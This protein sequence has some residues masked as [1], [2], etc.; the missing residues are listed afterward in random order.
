[1]SRNF[2]QAK[3]ALGPGWHGDIREVCPAAGKR[4]AQLRLQHGWSQKE[5]ALRLQV[6][7]GLFLHS[8]LQETW[9]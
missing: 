6:A 1:M 5:L 2:C 7:L 9:K 3:M 4:C 8:P